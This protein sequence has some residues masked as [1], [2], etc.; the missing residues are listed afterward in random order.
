MM[1]KK[2]SKPYFN[3]PNYGAKK[4]SRVQSRWRK[5]RGV[6][7]KKRTK[8]SFMG[9]EPTI[10]YKNP[11][12]ISGIRPSGKRAIHVSNKMELMRAI[13]SSEES[14]DVILSGSLSKRKRLEIIKIADGQKIK[15]ANRGS[16]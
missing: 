12:S 1:L 9:A 6:D 16:L 7:N 15:V 14:F 5:Q 8:H 10:G 4:R 2:K 3:I 13:E 11:D